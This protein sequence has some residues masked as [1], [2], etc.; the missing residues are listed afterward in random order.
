MAAHHFPWREAFLAA[1]RFMPVVTYACNVVDIVPSTAYR[2]RTLD[3]T[4][5][6]E[7]DEALEAGVDRAEIEAFRRGVDGYEE[8]VVYKGELMVVQEPHQVVDDDGIERTVWRPKLDP[9]G[10]PIPLTIRKHSDTMLGRVLAA[11]RSSYRTSA[12]EISN[13]DG[14]LQDG[15]AREARI[16]QI[17]AIAKARAEQAN[18]PQAANPED[19]A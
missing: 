2:Q 12:T 4:F 11:R 10:N 3:P 17:M 7:W 14:S 8:P 18:P 19:Y 13:P 1:L 16:A 6:K 15:V 9:R 5:A